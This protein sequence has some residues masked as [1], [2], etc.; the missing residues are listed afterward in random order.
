MF[1]VGQR[2]LYEHRR[3]R[4]LKRKGLPLNLF[5]STSK[6][7]TSRPYSS[8]QTPD[9]VLALPIPSSLSIHKRHPRRDYHV[10]PLAGK[11]ALYGYRFL[12]TARNEPL[13]FRCRVA[14]NFSSKSTVAPASL[15]FFFFNNKMNE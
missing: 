3:L 14:G 4:H 1:M 11:M 2:L 5:G 7:P 8:K 12:R 10:V 9:F 13:R 6:L 15:F